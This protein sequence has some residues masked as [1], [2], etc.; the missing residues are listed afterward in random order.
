MSARYDVSYTDR[1][2]LRREFPR[3][4]RPGARC[5]DCQQKYGSCPTC[6]ESREREADESDDTDPPFGLIPW[7][8][9]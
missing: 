3:A 8:R 9:N 1:S 6:E 7:G 2:D 5:P 4:P